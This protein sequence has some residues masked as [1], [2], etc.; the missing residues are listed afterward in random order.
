MIFNVAKYVPKQLAEEL[1]KNVS[2]GLKGI[3]SEKR[4]IILRSTKVNAKAVKKV[5][6]KKKKSESDDE[7]DDEEENYFIQILSET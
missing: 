1:L 6:K 5:D 7:N 4:V 3:L 2:I